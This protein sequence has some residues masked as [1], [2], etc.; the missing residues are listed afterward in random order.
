MSV[1]AREDA[2]EIHDSWRTVWR[3]LSSRATLTL[4]L[5]LV[6]AGV[7]ALLLLPQAPPDAR[8]DPVAYSRWEALA[9]Q[10]EGAFFEVANTIGL[11]N[12]VNAAWW[13]VSLAAG[14][15]LCALRLF[16]QLGDLAFAHRKSMPRFDEE[17]LQVIYD[18][19]PLDALTQA[20]RA[21][22]LT[23]KPVN[24]TLLVASSPVTATLASMLFHAGVTVLL[25]G[26]LVQAVWGWSLS[27]RQL[28]PAAPLTLPDRRTLVLNEAG[29]ITL[30]NQAIPLPELGVTASLDSL[31]VRVR[32]RLPGYRVSAERGGVSLGL[33]SSSFS[34][35]KPEAFVFFSESENEHFIAA[36]DGA[37]ALALRQV[38]T[39][40]PALE[41]F[42]LPSGELLLQTEVQPVVK[43]GAVLFRFDPTTGAVVDV[44]HYP[45]L[46]LLVLGS[47]LGGLGLLGI[48][49]LPSRRLVVQRH[50][51]WLEC[52]ARGRGVRQLW[53]RAVREATEIA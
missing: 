42:A 10:R 53:L 38:G 33:L 31:S 3:V 45:G 1:L 18:A 43:A 8:A 47:V 4:A 34:P 40:Q 39:Q 46:L 22:R 21:Q 6:G 26:L 5:A 17:R 19:P 27:E 7:T 9:R 50:E 15:T 37:I 2:L 41:A 11:N 12:V 48:L 23:V 36:P 20:L 35:A 14:I 28:T 25:I 16:G 49:L 32:Q 24:E 29:Q 30:G 44:S 13:R 51:H 52:Y